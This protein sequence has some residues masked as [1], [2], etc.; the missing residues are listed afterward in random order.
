MKP[1]E[2]PSRLGAR[3]FYVVEG[4]HGQQNMVEASKIRIG[5]LCQGSLRG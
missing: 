3:S 2:G 1:Q 4:G 5:R